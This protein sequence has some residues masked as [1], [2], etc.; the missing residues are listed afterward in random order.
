M[1]IPKQNS[2]TC[3]TCKAWTGHGASKYC[4][5]CKRRNLNKAL[6]ACAYLDC[7][8]VFKPT[9]GGAKYCWQHKG[10]RQKTASK[11]NDV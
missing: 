9:A 1:N 2:G 7:P 5:D 3:Q 4:L 11:K 8:E 6:R 10:M